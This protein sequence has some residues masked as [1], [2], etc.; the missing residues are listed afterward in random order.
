MAYKIY[1][2]EHVKNGRSALLVLIWWNFCLKLRPNIHINNENAS[3]DGVR[4]RYGI[5]GE[6]KGKTSANTHSEIYNMKEYLL[7]ITSFLFLRMQRYNFS[8]LFA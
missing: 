5:V 3:I 4:L 2:P 7:F 8:H 6:E 1:N